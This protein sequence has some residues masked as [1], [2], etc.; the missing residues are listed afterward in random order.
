MINRDRLYTNRY[1]KIEELKLA[2]QSVYFYHKGLERRSSPADDIVWQQSTGAR[3]VDVDIIDVTNDIAEIASSH[4]QFSLRSEEHVMRILTQTEP[5][6]IYLDSSGMSIRVLAPLLKCAVKLAETTKVHVYVVYI[7]PCVYDVKKFKEGGLFYDLAEGFNEL[8]PLPAFGCILPARGKSAFVPMLGFEG[9]R[10][11]HVLTQLSPEDDVIIPMIGV[12]GYRPE[13]PFVAYWGNKRPLEDTESWANVKYA[14]AGS[15]VDAF[16]ELIQIKNA[17][18]H[19]QHW[20]IAPIGTK[21]HTI[22]ALLFAILNPVK[23]EIIYDNPTRKEPRTKGVGCVS[24]TC[25]SDLIS[26]RCNA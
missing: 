17:H 13:Y 22:A 10:F 18:Q 1:A 23:T 11:A 4:E 19:V 14:M 6:E 7:E 12:S 15:V 20:K 5:S 9:G 3:F 16:F 26:G 24:V 8:S 21:P 2:D 25:I